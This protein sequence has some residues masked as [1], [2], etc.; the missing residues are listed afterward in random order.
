MSAQT[1][2]STHVVEPL[3]FD[4]ADGRS[5]RPPSDLREG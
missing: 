3:T 5:P 2:A 4:A 1:L